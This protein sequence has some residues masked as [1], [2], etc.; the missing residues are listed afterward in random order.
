MERV[1]DSVCVSN[2]LSSLQYLQLRGLMEFRLEASEFEN[3]ARWRWILT[4]S[5][6][7][8]IADH[9]VRLDAG[10]LQ[11][12]AFADLRQHLRLYAA[13]DQRI[14]DEAR[15]VAEVGAWMGAEVLGPVA[16]ALDSIRPATV[17]VVVPAEPAAARGLLYYPLELAYAGG[18]PL[19]LRGVTLV[20]QLASDGGMPP[21]RTGTEDPAE[22]LRVL[23]IFSLPV[24]TAALNL[25]RERQALV[26]RLAAVVDRVVDVHVLQYG[27]TKERLRDVL[28]DDHG[29]DV[30]HISGHGRPGELLLEAD[31]G[32][33]EA[34]SAADLAR[35]LE[36]TSQRVKLVTI[37]SCSS[38]ALD[39]ASKRRLLGLPEDV[40]GDA[41]EGQ[42]EDG[43]GGL[44][45]GALASE[46]ASRL[47]CAVLAMRYPVS[48]EFSAALTSRLYDLLITEAQTLPRAL[49]ASL[50]QAVASP[51]TAGCPA[52]SVATPALFGARAADLTLPGARQPPAAGDRG[53]PSS[54][55]FPPQPERFV[56]RTQVMARAGAVGVRASRTPGVLVFGMP[57]GGK[58]SCAL[59]LAYTH[60]HAFDRL[61]W[62]KVPDEGRESSGSLTEFAL[63][64]ERNLPGVR[65]VHLLDDR[66]SLTAYLPRLTETMERSRVLIVIDGIESLLTEEGLW[67]DKR[68]SQVM[69]ALCAHS[70]LGR[71]VVTSRRLPP[72]PAGT[73]APLGL[74]TAAVDALSLDEA[75]LLVAELPH[76]RAL[77]H[78]ELDAIPDRDAPRLTRGVLKAAQGHPKLLELADGQAADPARLAALLKAGDQA[79]R[80]VGGVPAGF[81]AGSPAQA[82]SG[83][84]LQVLD[85]WTRTV[86]AGLTRGERTLFGFLCCLEEKDRTPAVVGGN[87]SDLWQRLSLPGSPAALGPLVYSLGACGLLTI[88]AQKY[89]IH[90]GVAAAGRAQADGALQD[91]VDRELAVYWITRIEDA[92][93]Q[94]A[95]V[96]EDQRQ[97]DE[98]SGSASVVHAALAGVAY[99]LRLDQW[100]PAAEMLQEALI[101]DASRETAAA[102]LP[103]IQRVASAR[104]GPTIMGVLAQALEAV[105]PAKAEH[106]MR[107]SMAAAAASGQYMQA[108]S[109]G[110][111]LIYYC[112][113]KGHLAEA[114]AIADEAAS[115]TRRAGLGPWSRLLD[116]VRPLAVRSLMGEADHVFSEA[117][118]LSEYA[119]TLSE[120]S[121]RPESAIPWSVRETL[122]DLQ[123]AA[124]VQLE[125][126]SEALE[127]NAA[128]LT[129]M[130]GR[131]TLP[132]AIARAA[133]N[134]YAPLVKL[135]RY[136]DAYTCVSE[137][138]QVFAKANDLA[139]LTITLGCLADLEDKRGHSDAAIR[140]QQDHLRFGYLTGNVAEIATGYHHLGNLFARHL[141]QPDK[142]LPCHLAAALVRTVAGA[143]G[144]D[145]A[146][147]AVVADLEALGREAAVPAE[148]TELCRQAP[149]D[150]GARLIGLL[151]D[152]APETGRAEEVFEDLLVRARDEAAPGAAYPHW[153]AQWDPVLAAMVAARDGNQQAA[154]RFD[155]TVEG[156]LN[157][158]D[159][160]ALAAVLRRVRDGEGGLDLCAGLDEIDAAIAARAIGV[161][162]GQIA[163]PAGLWHAIATRV[164]LAHMVSAALGDP[165]DLAWAQQKLREMNAS[166]TGGP[167]AGVLGQIINGNRDRGVIRQLDDPR[168][169]DVARSMLQHVSSWHG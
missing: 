159:W 139:A 55:G 135:G 125:R 42:P 12:K 119:S 48:D 56:G 86:C 60:E 151:R 141:R 145:N 19:A 95:R 153:L 53:S 27:V 123:N 40:T 68:W 9:R 81:F 22:R 156:C 104:P 161:R 65:M 103:A 124:A 93:A 102:V 166:P 15:I 58:T 157:S 35:L 17:R 112:C 83:D 127:V 39:D 143:D 100:E 128:L 131:G 14:I 13:P 126:W 1:T 116:E 85:A 7:A 26:G 72:A 46:L 105:D 74:A 96:Q 66:E 154:A 47:N 41:V 138:R 146:V 82:S 134:D 115:Y 63:T 31:D 144:V 111:S 6:G 75:L 49:A 89:E 114:L 67:R 140:L 44:A 36:L 88:H 94:E 25:R 113:Q 16:A 4:G 11:Y 21:A 147:A 133:I 155:Q 18:G 77:M 130:R 142:G 109:A 61:G 92:Q 97:D 2:V 169:R 29:W 158:P 32:T 37:S 24:G 34:V 150:T 132:T 106:R 108:A 148:V 28:A 59:E 23:G 118:R 43:S 87:W 129:S 160:G 84:Y 101:R 79:W 8:V 122:L 76:L 69:G 167:L 45:P 110:G 71:V 121:D 162:D 91:A 152:L 164:W 163:I 107:A 30:I 3:L 73:A 70:G 120:T 10:S 33:P 168:E 137:C 149:D 80:L 117:R 50:V 98:S 90:S 57:C 5:D 165:D 54:A 99:L 62:F 78:G 136:D 64:L 52:L 20:M 38:A 51:P